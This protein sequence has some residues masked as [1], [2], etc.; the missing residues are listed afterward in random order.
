M[1]SALR[2]FMQPVAG[3][4]GPPVAG[5]TGA[6]PVAGPSHSPITGPAGPPSDVNPA[7]FDPLAEIEDARA[8]RQ[9]RAL[10]LLRKSETAQ[11]TMCISSSLSP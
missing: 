8:R 2:Q 4:S 3:P 1:A 6:P 5:P 11:G 10:G 7:Q 9:D